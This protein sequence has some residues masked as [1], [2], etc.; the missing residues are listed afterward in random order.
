MH[1][2]RITIIFAIFLLSISACAQQSGAVAP[3]EETDDSSV[4]NASAYEIF[5]REDKSHKAT[6]KPIA[7]Y[8]QKELDELP[9]AKQIRYKIVVPESFKAEQ[10]RPTINKFIAD[11]AE[12]DPDIDEIELHIYSEKSRLNGPY[13]VAKAVWGVGGKLEKVGPEVAIGNKRDDYEIKTHIHQ[14]LDEYLEKRGKF[15]G[16]DIDNEENG[17]STEDKEAVDDILEGLEKA[18]ATNSAT[19]LR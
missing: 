13:D 9:D 15:K 4:E 3:P 7:A 18:P 8:T 17:L 2:A 12:K 5:S 10:A 6:T 14:D 11:M 16:T 19:P 1:K